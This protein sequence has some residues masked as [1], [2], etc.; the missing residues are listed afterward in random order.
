MGPVFVH[1]RARARS[2]SN[3]AKDRLAGKGGIS[4]RA[5]MG[6]ARLPRLCIRDASH[7]SRGRRGATRGGQTTLSLR[8]FTPPTLPGEGSLPRLLLFAHFAADASLTRMNRPLEPGG[9]LGR[10]GHNV[11]CHPSGLLSDSIR[12]L[13]MNTTLLIYVHFSSK[14]LE[15]V[16]LNCH[17]FTASQ[18]RSSPILL[19]CVFYSSEF[20]LDILL[21]ARVLKT[22]L[23]TRI[24][25]ILNGESFAR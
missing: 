4:W 14:P 25:V 5:H 7:K 12:S 22:R 2:S 24:V 16:H 23:D 13:N 17:E 21:T 10:I 3:K 20:D 19:S 15:H 9:T 6:S 11:E 8:H 18:K 1:Q